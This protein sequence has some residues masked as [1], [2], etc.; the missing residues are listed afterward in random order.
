MSEIFKCNAAPYGVIHDIYVHVC[1]YITQYRSEHNAHLI[2]MNHYDLKTRWIRA[3][4]KI[5]RVNNTSENK[6]V[7]D[8]EHE[9]TAMLQTHHV[10]SVKTETNS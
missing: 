6:V 9:L 3:D 10:D 7:S 1:T 2:D 4:T 8:Q 5:A